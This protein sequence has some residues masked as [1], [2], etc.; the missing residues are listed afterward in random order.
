MNFKW[1]LTPRQVNY[2]KVPDGRSPPCRK[3]MKDLAKMKVFSKLV[4]YFSGCSSPSWNPWPFIFSYPTSTSPES[5]IS[6]TLKMGLESDH[7]FLFLNSNALTSVQT[8]IISHWAMTMVWLCLPFSP[9]QSLFHTIARQMVQNVSGHV[10]PLFRS[11]KVFPLAQFV[12]F[13]KP[14]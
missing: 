4:F 8:I 9:L 1:S 11:P 13:F 3:S 14:I 6:S 12:F 10:A 7:F 5:T 2:V